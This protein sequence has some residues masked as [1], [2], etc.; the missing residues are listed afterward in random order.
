MRQKRVKHITGY[1]S[2]FQRQPPCPEGKE[3]PLYAIELV[4]V[5]LSMNITRIFSIENIGAK[6]A[7]RGRSSAIRLHAPWAEMSLRLEFFTIS[8]FRERRSGSIDTVNPAAKRGIS[9]RA[10]Q[11]GGVATGA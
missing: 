11:A 10:G 9:T 3:T 6:R 1:C 4:E 7:S 5:N 8:G 2:H